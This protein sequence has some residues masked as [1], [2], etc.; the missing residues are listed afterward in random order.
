MAKDGV[1]MGLNRYSN[2]FTGRFAAENFSDDK[3]L[4]DVLRQA[5]EL[6]PLAEK[7][8]LALFIICLIL[9]IVAAFG[10]AFP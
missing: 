1:Q 8:S 7:V 2:S 3:K 10:L 5:N 4:L 9:F 6:F